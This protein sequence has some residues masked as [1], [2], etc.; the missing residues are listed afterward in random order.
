MVQHPSE[1][2]IIFVGACAAAGRL[3]AANPGLEILLVEQGP[4]NLNDPSI[5]TPG[6][7]KEHL[8]P[9]SKNTLTW[10]AN[11]SDMLNG[12]I[13]I[14]YSGGV[15]GGGSSMNWMVYSRPSASDFDDWNVPG[16]GSK[17][18]IPLLRKLETYHPATGRDT[19]GYDGP[20]H[21]SYSNHY[22][23]TAQEYLDV[24][25]R[26][27]VPLVEDVMD[28]KTGHGC[29]TGHRQDAA[30]RYIHSQAS[31]KSL[32]IL[33]KTMVV[34]V[35]FH[36]IKATG[37]EVVVNKRQVPDADQTPQ[38]I[39]AR[40]L[41]VV[42][43]GTIGSPVVLQR[44]GLGCAQRLSKIGI[45]CIADLPDMGRQ[46]KDHTSVAS[47]YH[48]AN[49]TETL[50]CLIN[51][52]PGFMERCI[53]EFTNGKGFLTSNTIDA[54]SK[55][56][57]TPRE[58]NDM[59][60][61]F[62]EVWK[63]FYE[64]APDKPVV[65]ETVLNGF[66]RPQSGVPGGDRFMLI[67]HMQGYPVSRGHV[68]ITSI[69]PYAPPDFESGFLDEQADVD[70]LVWG[71][72][73]CRQVF[74]EVARRMPSYRG[75]YVLQHPKFPEG[76]AAACVRLDRPPATEMEDIVYTLEDNAAILD[77]VRQEGGTTWHGASTREPYEMQA[78]GTVAMKPREKG[79]CVDARLNVYGTAD[80]KVADLSI[81]PDNVGANTN[82]TA[83]L[84][85]EKAA[86]LIAEDL[87]LNVP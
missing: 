52:E 84:V 14:V 28:T 15:L 70:V 48:V 44:S 4:N 40:K 59:G 32:H 46:Y 7:A 75:E 80:L 19:H 43:S 8:A 5:I 34:R 61:A 22:S 50:D 62:L 30:H 31:N 56:R 26:R 74:A 63:R 57:P 77:F 38:I 83:L 81:L 35:I 79:G 78:N 39:T 66:P 1:V 29:Q 69:D 58:L 53:A 17:D 16:W 37:V 18:L 45:H 25:A 24:C 27:G 64:P 49:D 73:K 87:K 2:D 33:T 9:D 20:V 65:L 23:T 82:C 12:R 85:G 6:L 86:M 55:L 42:S 76:S 11:K 13:P 36:G 10:V 71:Y 54:G 47:I 21:I 67:A 3:A 72:K 68:Y 41:V 60:P 51:Q